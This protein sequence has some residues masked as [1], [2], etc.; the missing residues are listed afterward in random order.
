MRCTDETTIGIRDCRIG[1]SY[2]RYD[3]VNTEEAT[4]SV[5]VKIK[6]WDV[7]ADGVKG[8]NDTRL[9]QFGWP[10]ACTV[11]DSLRQRQAV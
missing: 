7:F 10:A 2:I 4:M 11:H 5:V 8:G 9:S 1:H 6:G 3:L